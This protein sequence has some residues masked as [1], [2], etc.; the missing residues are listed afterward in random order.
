MTFTVS[1]TTEIIT[2]GFAITPGLIVKVMFTTDI[3]GT[4]FANKIEVKFGH[5]NPCKNHNMLS[6]TTSHNGGDKD[7]GKR[8]FGYCPGSEGRAVGL[9]TSRPPL[10]TLLGDWM[11][12]GVLYVVTPQTRFQ[13]DGEFNVLDRVKVEFVRLSDNSLV[14]TKIKKAND[15]G[16]GG[17]S[18]LSLFIGTVTTKPLAFVGDWWIEDEPFVA[19]LQTK[20]VERGALLGEGAYVLVEYKITDN[21]RL[22]RRI[23]AFVPP[24][25]GDDNTIGQLQSVG[26]PIIAGAASVLQNDEVWTVDGVDFIVSEAT[27]LVDSG[28]ELVP[29]AVV[30][31]NSY[32]D[33]GQRHATMIRTQAG[34]AYLPM[35]GW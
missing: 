26:G 7:E 12:D 24:G 25:A 29:G 5:N 17:G 8:F 20:F 23:V 19:T 27:Q 11:V 31:V 35:L 3:S 33:N 18:D 6:V 21:V 1:S 10:G 13:G 22:I 9:I 34:R 16:G 32:T 4:N 14:A 30:H 15:N 2:R 28:G